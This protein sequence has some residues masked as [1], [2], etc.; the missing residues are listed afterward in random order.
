MTITVAIIVAVTDLMRESSAIAVD[1]PVVKSAVLGTNLDVPWSQPVQVTDPFEGNYLAVFDRHYFYRNV[2]NRRTKTE[3]VSL[4]SPKSVRF[5][6]ADD[7]YGCF[8]GGYRAFN[9]LSEPLIGLPLSSPN[10]VTS[11]IREVSQLFIKVDQQVFRL[12]G[13]N[14]T[15]AVSDQLAK[16]LQRSSAGVVNIRLVTRSGESVDSEIG[17]GTIKAW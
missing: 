13:Q 10:C 6:M 15:F 1:V 3:V 17:T 11:N 4:W 12:E 5:L 8:S 7:N 2:L 9:S 16:A 14:S